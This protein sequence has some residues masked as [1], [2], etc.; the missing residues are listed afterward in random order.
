M[1]QRS[2]KTGK[3]AKKQAK[4]QTKVKPKLK[5]TLKRKPVSRPLA[6]DDRRWLWAAYV[7]GSFPEKTFPAGLEIEDFN[8][9]VDKQIETLDEAYMLEMDDRPVG[10][11]GVFLNQRYGYIEPHVIWF[12][13]A[14][15]RNK[16]EAAVKFIDKLRKKVPMMIIVDEDTKS[17]FTHIE[18]HGI[19]KR[20]GTSHEAMGRK[21]LLFESRGKL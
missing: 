12:E 13:W 20:I 19:I 7:K 14:T 6:A 21:K 18:R 16:I 1:P 17:F 8:E 15:T 9:I 11:V 2:P 5:R 10:L 4:T 3:Q